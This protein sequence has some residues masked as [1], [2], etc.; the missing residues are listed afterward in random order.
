MACAIRGNNDIKGIQ[1]PGEPGGKELEAK[2]SMLADDTQLFNKYERSV[3]KSFDILSKY[4]KA[5]GLRINY[6]KTKAI[7]IGTARHRKPTFNK[8]SW[9]KENVK[10]LGVHHG[11]NVHNDKIWKDII[12]RMKNCIQVWKSRTLSYKGKTIIVKNL[13]LSYCGFEIETKGIL[14]KVKKE[15][16]TLIWD[17]I[18]E[19]KVNQIKRDVCCLDIENG[20]MSMVN[21]DSYIDSRRIQFIYRII[22]E[23]I[24]NWNAIGKYW[25]S[26]LDFKFNETF[27]YLQML[28]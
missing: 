23:P 7:S 4:E 13:L 16:E 25:L 27:F 15:I 2:I 6:N 10:T 19:G 5:S 28:K 18:W 22:N 21:R 17:F 8:I 24:E 1:L 20:G 26:R 11:Y 12:D 14:D 3:E 9:I